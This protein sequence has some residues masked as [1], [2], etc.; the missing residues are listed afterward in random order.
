MELLYCKF[1]AYPNSIL[2]LV[3]ANFATK[4]SSF[5]FSVIS[6]STAANIKLSSLG[7]VIVVRNFDQE[8]ALRTRVPKKMLSP[9][10]FKKML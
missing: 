4:Y 2:L 5:I 6:P 10:E 3:D 1:C 9:V 7:W 8:G